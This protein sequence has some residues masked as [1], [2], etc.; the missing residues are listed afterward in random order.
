MKKIIIV[1]DEI[2]QCRGLQNLLRRQY[3]NLEIQIFTSASDA[4]NYIE[5]EPPEIVITDICMPNM[6]GLEM[7]DSIKKINSRIIVILLT[8]YAEFEYA[9]KAIS[10][11]AFEYLIKPLNPERLKEVLEKAEKELKNA[12][13]LSVQHEK[14]QQQLD[15]ALPVYMENI[16]NQWVYGWSTSQEKSEIEKIIPAGKDGFLV[17]T[18]LP[19]MTEKKANL[20]KKN[21]EELR[22]QIIWWMRGMVRHPWHCLSFFSNVLK[23]TMVTI[24]VFM[25]KT[26]NSLT[27][28]RASFRN[29]EHVLE[30][31]SCISFPR[32]ETSLSKYQM[33]IGELQY[34][35]WNNIESSYQ[36]IVSVL[37]FFFYF[38]ENMILCS[39]YIRR[40]LIGQIRIGLTEEEALRE[41]VKK[42]EGEKAKEIFRIVWDRCCAGGYPDPSQLKNSFKNILEHMAFSM[43][44]QIA[45]IDD[46]EIDSWSVFS[47]RVEDYLEKLAEERL[48][49][50]GKKSADIIVQL[51]CY[52]EEHFS[53]EI[54]LDDLAVYFGVTP[55]YC[56]KLIKDV[57]DDNFSKLLVRKRIKKAKEFLRETEMHIYEIAE[58]TGY[59]DVKYF[60]RVFK[61]ETGVTPIQYRKAFENQ[62]GGSI[63]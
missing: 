2:R 42:G 63:K 3:E 56:S 6:S 10:V 20:D 16:L 32:K 11:G 44:S 31:R 22:S 23:D 1:D 8:G 17:V 14:M 54:T 26:G 36:D 19:G 51:D 61:K 59:N 7:T 18:Y 34:D 29:M 38:P 5:K 46:K 24:V 57:T 58:S 15:M 4:L 55:A 39:A 27:E 62:G 9:Q 45:F 41:A 50:M 21:A 40:H 53:E 33:V 47:S 60:N 37:P 52:L 13:V 49:R 28:K 30:N 35:L 12:E 48:S 25:G 43:C